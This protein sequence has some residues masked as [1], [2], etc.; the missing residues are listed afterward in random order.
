MRKET[1][2][3]QHLTGTVDPVFGKGRLDPRHHG[4]GNPGHAVPPLVL[5]GHISFPLLGYCGASGEADPTID[6]GCAAVLPTVEP[7]QVSEGQRPEADHLYS[8]ALEVIPETLLELGSSKAVD[9]ETHLDPI[10]GSVL[11]HLDE[12]LANLVG[13]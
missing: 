6:D 7:H 4:A 9:Q 13:L 12:L 1:G 2:T 10:P 5:V 3:N 11:E 8:S